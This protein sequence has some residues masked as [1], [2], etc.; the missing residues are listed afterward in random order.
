[1]QS[2]KRVKL[3]HESSS[4]IEAVECTKTINDLPAELIKNIFSF[5]GKG[6]Y[7]FVAPVSKD[8]CFNFLTMDLIEDKFDHKLDYIQ[9]IGRNKVTTPEAASTSMELAEHCF[10]YAP[11]EFNKQV[12]TKAALNGRQD[13]VNFGHAMG[14]EF[15]FRDDEAPLE[16]AKKGDLG[17]LQ[18]LY[19]KYKPRLCSVFTTAAEHGHFDILH[20]MKKMIERG[21]GPSFKDID[22][23]LVFMHA[24][25][26]GHKE[27]IEWLK[28]F[29]EDHI[30]GYTFDKA[31]RLFSDFIAAAAR[32]GQLELLKW[33]SEGDDD[34][35]RDVETLIAATRSGNMELINYL[36]DHGCPYDDPELCAAAA[37][38]NDHVKSL[39][40]LTFLHNHSAPWDEDTCY[41]AASAGNFNA[42]IYARRNGCPWDEKTL[43]EAIMEGNTPMLEYCLQNNC[44]V[45]DRDC[46]LAARL[47]DHDHALKVLKVLRE[48]SVPWDE[49]TCVQAARLGN[50][51]VLEWARSH[52]CPWSPEV[53][54]FAIE[55]ENRGVIQY[56]IENNCP[57]ENAAEFIFDHV[58]P[59]SIL[60][61]LQKNGY[62]FTQEF[63]TKALRE[64]DIIALRWLR[65][66]G[67]P[68]DIN[69][70][71]DE[72][73]QR[74]NYD[75]LV[76]THKN[77]GILT[78]ETY[79]FCFSED[80]LG[81]EYYEKPTELV[82]SNEILGYLVLNHCPRPDSSDW[83]VIYS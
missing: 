42:L 43:K 57:M 6:N 54:D 2:T 82:C 47:I 83:N 64:D 52:G 49:S 66:I 7:C 56:C 23:S 11:D 75:A 10:F 20:W 45:S 76:Y 25:K 65:Y 72:A 40:I 37:Y 73:V 68:W 26:G 79:A 41:K 4:A 77:G 15:R 70:I 38:L 3:G 16:I 78:K 69:C 44:P 67:C 74:D 48:H 5:V 62:T 71:C 17:M 46:D 81:G 61:I 12:L 8:F 50:L 33:L 51:K 34:A 1:M 27:V 80:G 28:A 30:A 22:A 32:G 59:L 36:V 21:E 39:E 18:L 14:V 35:L 60:K 13:I 19:H 55:S 24:A 58:D 9:A 31:N 29:A 63:C 53:F